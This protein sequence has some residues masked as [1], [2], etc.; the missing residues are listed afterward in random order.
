MEPNENVDQ[1]IARHAEGRA[2]SLAKTVQA[3]RA[4][5]VKQDLFNLRGLPRAGS[6]R[7]VEARR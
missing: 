5:R 1:L 7:P 6:L 3:R 4:R 2:A